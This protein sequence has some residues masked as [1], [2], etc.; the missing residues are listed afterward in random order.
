MNSNISAEMLSVSVNTSLLE[1]FVFL[2]IYIAIAIWL[3]KFVQQ[4]VK[5]QRHFSLENV[6]EEANRSA[7]VANQRASGDFSK[8]W[9]AAGITEPSA[10][11]VRSLNALREMAAREDVEKKE[12][13]RTANAV[14]SSMAAQGVAREGESLEAMEKRLKKEML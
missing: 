10:D 3:F 12:I 8:L 5:Q 9:K 6:S 1:S 4:N 13:E 7:N 2:V 11:L 14:A